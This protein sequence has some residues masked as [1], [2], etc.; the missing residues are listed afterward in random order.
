LVLVLCRHVVL[1]QNKRMKMIYVGL[2]MQ[3][4][5]LHTTGVGLKFHT[6]RKHTPASVSS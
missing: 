5:L 6:Q 1:V 3:K 4:M 2:I